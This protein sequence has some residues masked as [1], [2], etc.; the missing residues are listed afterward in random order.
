VLVSISNQVAIA[1]ERKRAE[2][3]LKKRESLITSLYQISNAIHTTSSL[4]Q[5]Y[6]SIHESLKSIIDVRNFTIALYD[7]ERDLLFFPFV[8]DEGNPQIPVPDPIADISQTNTPVFEVIRGGKAVIF[9]ESEQK[10]LAASTFHPPTD[11]RTKPWIGVPLTGKSGVLGVMILRNYPPSDGYETADEELL[12]T[13]SNQI[14]SAIEH[15]RAETELATTQK[16]LM[17]KAH[18]AGMA[19]IASD[20]L[21]NIGNILNSVKTSND[22]IKQITENS[23]IVDLSKGVELIERHIN[24]I[25]EFVRH[26]PK[27]QKLMRYL[28]LVEKTLRKE[29]ARIAE[30]S[31]RLGDKI[32]LMT[33]VIRTQ[34]DYAGAGFMSEE[35]QLSEIIDTVLTSQ[36]DMLEEHGITVIK[37]YD[38]TSNVLAQRT[39]LSQILINLINNAKDAMDNEK[40]RKKEIRI[41]LE[42][43]NDSVFLKI[44]DTGC[45]I[46]K[47][48]LSKIF[49]HG[50]T[51]KKYG[52][53]FG[54]HNSANYMS[55]M[56]G[57]MW[58]ESEGVDQ[59]STIVL[60][61]PKS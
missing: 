22:M 44:S 36:A 6:H 15:K 21:H 60:K 30:H 33:N 14:A 11:P 19:D 53:G 4:D 27:G 1:I 13:V 45:G 40:P 58:A 24:S 9:D 55:E 3:R 52:H 7:N 8:V 5:L 46:S 10:E 43:D 25:D 39:R 34:L 20:T 48:R 57:T 18:M 12:T 16:H 49:T 61:F 56:N 26:D 37:N 41:N 17:E 50:F 54:L 31:K 59:G 38:K 32:D 2:E 23:Y 35:Y 28:P 42:Q 29:I 51:T 47:E